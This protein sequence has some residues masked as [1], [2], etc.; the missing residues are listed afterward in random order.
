VLNGIAL[1]NFRWA[2]ITAA[3]YPVHPAVRGDR[4]AI[5]ALQWLVA[6]ATSYFVIAAQ[7]RDLSA[8]LPA[9]LILISLASAA[10]LQRIPEVFFSNRLVEPGLLVLNSALILI[11]IIT[12]FENPWDLVVLFFFC[13]FIAA[14]VENLIQVATGCVLLS[15]VFVLFESPN[16]T[17]LSR[18]DANFLFRV[19]F[20]FAISIFYGHLASEVKREKKRAERIEEVSSLKRQMACALAHDMKTPLNVILG[21]AELLAGPAERSSPMERQSSFARIRD[22]IDRIV[23]LIAEFLDVAKLE[24]S[25]VSSTVELVHMNAVAEDVVMQQ[26]ITARE[27]DLQL[28]L[29]LDPTL[30]PTVG[31]FN[32]LHRALS[33]LVSNAIKFTPTGGRVSVSSRMIKKNL[34]IEVKDTGMGIATDEI[35]ALFSEFRRLKGAAKMEGTGLGLFIVKTIVEAHGGSVS[36]QSEMG[37]GSTFTMVLPAAST[38]ASVMIRRAA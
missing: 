35:S 6:I 24:T 36:V 37:V 22:N 4:N 23:Q 3:D 28:E 15:L 5:I 21:H 29:K 34:A 33:N 31:D 26:T 18:V 16:A 14:T 32:Q 11:A 30:E 1:A 19:P 10:L 38:S 17:D 2:K 9:L 13:L 7:D 12:S 25:K 8:P 20:M 27:K